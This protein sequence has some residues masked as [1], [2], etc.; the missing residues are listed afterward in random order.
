MLVYSRRQMNEVCGCVA[1][2]RKAVCVG[3]QALH[4]QMHW[5]V[6]QFCS[7]GYCMVTSEQVP[8]SN[9]LLNV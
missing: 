5:C 1:E 3:R 4:A 2:W 6:R 8:R 9:G 7:W